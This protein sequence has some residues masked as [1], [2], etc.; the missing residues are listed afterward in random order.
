M[1]LRAD[2]KLIHVKE[3]VVSCGREADSCKKGIWFRVDG[4]LIRVKRYAVLCGRR[5]DSCK[6]VCGFKNIRISVDRAL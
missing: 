3:Y 6:K 5:V 1:R 4:R 2:G